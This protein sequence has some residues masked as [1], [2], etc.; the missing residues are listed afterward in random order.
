MG[1]RG[2][3]W[4]LAW[5]VAVAAGCA[6]ENKAYDP[7]AAGGTGVATGEV[8]YA[9]S[10]GAAA[11]ASGDASDT[12]ATATT[13]GDGEGGST[14]MEPPPAQWWDPAYG[15]RIRLGFEPLFGEPLD[16]FVAAVELDEL[17]PLFDLDPAAGIATVDPD[18]MQPVPHEALG[19]DPDDGSMLL[20]V[21]L[22]SWRTGEHTPIDLYVDGPI[23]AHVDAGLVWDEGFAGVWHLDELDRETTPNAVDEAGAGAL[24]GL[25]NTAPPAFEPGVVGGAAEFD[26]YDDLI[27]VPAQQI[28]TPDESPTLT[29]SAWA[30]L[31]SFAPQGAPVF[32]FSDTYGTAPEVND[33]YLRV[34]SDRAQTLIRT[35]DDDTFNPLLWY[36][37]TGGDPEWHHV[38]MVYDGADSLVL[39]DGIVVGDRPLIGDVV[40][41]SASFHIGGWGIVDDFDPDD[42]D[43]T[44]HGGIDEVRVSFEARS[45]EWIH[46]S[47]VNMANPPGTFD[48]LAVEGL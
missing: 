35:T 3:Q 14:D 11:D 2:G 28:G 15:T 29:V 40:F 5:W 27:E 43:R 12:E 4:T 9:T 6:A 25:G 37:W 36:D 46:A 26:G 30:R 47:F 7:S 22:P 45:L 16:G 23:D 34:Y 21:R 17:E 13:V 1:T 38:A 10:D 48:V 24:L 20:W 32:A 8:P 39:F 44:W 42:G 18:T 41:D 33:A 19:F 31:E